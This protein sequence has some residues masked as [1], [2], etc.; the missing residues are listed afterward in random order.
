MS[1]MMWLDWTPRA[2]WPTRSWATSSITPSMTR[3]PVI[4]GVVLNV[5]HDVVGLDAA[6][7]LADHDAGEDGVFAGVLEVAAVAGLADEVHA[8]P[9]GHAV[10][11]G[12]QLA[13][14]D[15]AI[16]EGGVGVP[17]RG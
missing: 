2:S 7:E 12:A 3:K 10:A 8:A 5:A 17:G 15:G 6:G 4:E 1:P 11:L 16:E 13:A 14:D 9:D